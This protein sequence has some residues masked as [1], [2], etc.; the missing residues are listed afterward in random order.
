[1]YQQLEEELNEEFARVA[2][3]RELPPSHKWPWTMQKLLTDVG[4]VATLDATVDGKGYPKC[5][6]TPT[7]RLVQILREERASLS[8]AKDREAEA[9][10][11]AEANRR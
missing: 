8:R 4:T 1:M 11:D 9:K 5:W 6:T 10:R 3:D 2:T 7:R